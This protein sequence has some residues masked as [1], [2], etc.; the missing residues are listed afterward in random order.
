M[1]NYFYWNYIII[2]II[3]LFKLAWTDIVLVIVN[4]VVEMAGIE[5]LYQIVKEYALNIYQIFAEN[6]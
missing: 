2:E 1:L 4:R 3:E 5:L 6:S